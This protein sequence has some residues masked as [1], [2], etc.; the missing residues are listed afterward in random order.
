MNYSIAAFSRLSNVAATMGELAPQQFTLTHAV[1]PDATMAIPEDSS[2]S[3]KM[4]TTSNGSNKAFLQTIFAG[5]LSAF[6]GFA[7]S[8]AIVVQGLISVGATVE[9]AAS[10]LMAAA[11]LMGICGIFLSLKH[12]MPI[13]I[14]WS[15]PGAALLASSVGIEGGFSTAVGAFIVTALLIVLTGMWKSLSNVFSAVPT[16]LA[17]AML[18]GILLPLCLA[19]FEAVVSLPSYAIP[20]IVTWFVFGKFNKLLAMPAAVLVTLLLIAFVTDLSA[21]NVTALWPAPAFVTPTLSL[22]ALIGIAIPLYIVTMTSQ[23]LPGM[24]ILHSFNYQ[25]NPN[26]LFN[27]TGIFSLF[28][29]P[30]GGH[31]S[32]WSKRQRCGR[33][34]H[35]FSSAAHQSCRWFGPSERI[36]QF[37]GRRVE[38]SR[39]SRVGNHHLFNHCI[40]D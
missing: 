37:T 20:I 2:G 12:R 30:F 9:Q 34:N 24:A 22:S 35:A 40:G 7:G 1:F 5:S 15:T 17:Q 19:P 27:W 3:D 10:G 26:T 33:T 21:M 31:S 23:N 14:V 6:V 8:F 36:C 38:R 13:S 11:I 16:C 25:P 32:L 28:A 4:P 39:R 18:A 29:A